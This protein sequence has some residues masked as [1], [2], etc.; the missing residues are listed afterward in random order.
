MNSSG[1]TNRYSNTGKSRRC[2][3]CSRMRRLAAFKRATVRMRNGALWRGHSA[4]CRD[5]HADYMSEYRQ[6]PEAK[7]ANLERVR[8]AMRTP[9]YRAKHVAYTRKH[10]QSK[11]GRRWTREYLARYNS[12][13]SVRMAARMRAHTRRLGKAGGDLTSA[14]WRRIVRAWNSMCAYCSRRS[15]KLTIDHVV[16]LVSGG[17]HSASNVVPACHSCNCRKNR[18][19]LAEWLSRAGITKAE[20]RKR[21]AAAS[22]RLRSMP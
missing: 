6:R 4:W 9:E 18:L 2:S 5:C 22:R 1:T 20:W 7:R 19:G 15:A 10:R 13:P 3:R 17:L 21:C 11:R 8:R 14:S 12:R 16:P